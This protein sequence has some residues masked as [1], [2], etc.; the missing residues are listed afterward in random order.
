MTETGTEWVK[1][2]TQLRNNKSSE[3]SAIAL[4]TELFSV[5]QHHA[6]AALKQNEV[7]HGGDR[8]RKARD[9]RADGARVGFG[10]GGRGLFGVR[11]V[12]LERLGRQLGLGV[13]TLLG[14]ALQG[15]ALSIFDTICPRVF[16][17]CQMI[18]ALA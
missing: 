10:V 12:G 13:A 5:R 15:V 4:H 17:T 11:R 7:L 3:E 16:E 18:A 2:S 6:S 9:L 1:V 14:R 8:G